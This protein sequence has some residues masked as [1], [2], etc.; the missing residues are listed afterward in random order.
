VGVDKVLVHNSKCSSNAK[1]LRKNLEA[2]GCAPGDYEDAAHI[3]ASGHK[4]HERAR[5]I[6]EK[7]GIDINDA[8]NGSGLPR[9]TKVP[10]PYGKTTHNITHRHK[11]MDKVRLLRE[12]EKNGTVKETLQLINRK[13]QAGTF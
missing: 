7:A 4:R 3:V 8:V 9:N 6:L 5:K 10:N 12:A 1:K 11:V 2:D 13:L